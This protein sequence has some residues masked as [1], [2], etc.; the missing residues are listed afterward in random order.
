LLDSITVTH[1]VT[2]SVQIGCVDRVDRQTLHV[3]YHVLTSWHP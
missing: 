3:T 2:C 1:G